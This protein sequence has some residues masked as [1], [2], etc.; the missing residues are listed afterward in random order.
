MLENLG[1][2][3]V[4]VLLEVAQAHFEGFLHRSTSE[5]KVIG[6]EEKAWLKEQKKMLLMSSKLESFT[7]LQINV[8]V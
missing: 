4:N 1:P 5:L 8:P 7:D 2:S 3:A 6:L